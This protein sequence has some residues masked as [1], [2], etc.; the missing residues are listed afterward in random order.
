MYIY[1]YIYTHT[2]IHT[3]IHF[4]FQRE[5]NV[6][7]LEKTTVNIVYGKNAVYSENHMEDVNALCGQMQL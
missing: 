2:H 7:S 5:K 3:H 6:L 4:I 1:I